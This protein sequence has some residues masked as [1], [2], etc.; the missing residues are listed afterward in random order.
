M[1]PILERCTPN[2]INITVNCIKGLS[3]DA[4]SFVWALCFVGSIFLIIILL[5]WIHKIFPTSLD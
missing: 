5:F 1:I 2:T 4:T 3:Y